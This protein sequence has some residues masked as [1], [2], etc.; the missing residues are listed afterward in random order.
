MQAIITRYVSAT[1]TKPSRI[2]ASCARGAVLVSYPSE[3]SGDAV[4]SYAAD[5]LVARF[6]KEDAKQYGTPAA[7]NPWGRSRVVG[8][9]PSGDMAHV[10]TS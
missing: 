10:F 4:H 1:N 9:L 2:K 7:K 5:L 8:Q 6:I 3:L